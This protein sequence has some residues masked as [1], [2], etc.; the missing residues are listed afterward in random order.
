[1]LHSLKV[2]DY[3]DNAG[4]SA[5]ILKLWREFWFDGVCQRLTIGKMNHC[6]FLSHLSDFQN[7]KKRKKLPSN[8]YKILKFWIY[9]YSKYD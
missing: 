3:E 4:G 9:H 1:M 7:E 2:Q 6:T 5:F 8:S